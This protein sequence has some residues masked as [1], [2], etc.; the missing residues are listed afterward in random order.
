MARRSADVAFFFAL[1]ST[2]LAL[3][4]ALAHAL[5]LP[6][7]IG[8]A[9]DAYFTVQQI[10][11]GWSL[12]GWLLL[13]QFASMIVAARAERHSAPTF[14]LVV[15]ALGCLVAAQALFWTFT[16]PANRATANWT[17]E[18]ANWQTLRLDWEVSHAVGALLQM[19]AMALLIL[20]VLRRR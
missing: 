19:L 17:V 4:G 6:N 20:A 18:P 16:F 12:L 7:K 14:R 11:R 13:V 8:L 15:G 10:Y 2:A 3:G 5:E 9:R 1:L